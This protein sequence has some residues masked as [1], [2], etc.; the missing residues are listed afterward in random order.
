MKALISLLFILS[1]AIVFSQDIKVLSAKTN[2]GISGVAI[3]NISKTKSAI[4]DLD[5]KTTLDNFGD[6]EIV[7]FK[8]ISYKTVRILKKEILKNQNEILLQP[9]TQSLDEIV[10]SASKFNQA[11]KEIPQKIISLNSKS[12]QFS[13]PQTSADLLGNSGNVYI[14]KSQLGGGS[15]MIRGFSTNRLLIS[16]DDVRM[17]NAI[18]RG[19]NL[20][21]VISIDPFSIQ[22]T[23]VTL[24]SGSV[25]YGSDAIGGV[26]SFYTKKPQLS[27]KDSLAFNANSTVRYASA[28]NEKT[29]HIDFNLG[30]KK[31]AFLSNISYTDFGDLTMGK[32]GPTDYLR[33]EYVITNNNQDII[34]L[35]ND[36]LVQKPTG[37]SQINILEKIKFEPTE[38]LYFNLGF[39]YSETSDYS[40]YDRLLR[41][42]GEN[43][44]SAEW[45]YGPQKWFMA[46]FKVTKLSSRST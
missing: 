8:H 21:N 11:K 4:T 26:M 32:H 19:G 6:N 3:Y 7:Y 17:N 5:G 29:A 39:H 38:N 33:N 1:S 13:N 28:S 42:N 14:Q 35:N 46:N 43:L 20:Q 34:V 23:E 41:Y 30:L 25:I 2:Q 9:I 22:N 16:V 37:Y 40:R 12:I 24:G 10:V 18:F 45:Y 31:W 27:Y 36:P 15:P 44:R